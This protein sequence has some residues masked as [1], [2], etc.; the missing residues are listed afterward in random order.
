MSRI[1]MTW[2]QAEW[3]VLSPAHRRS[4]QPVRLLRDR[5]PTANRTSLA[6]G[7]TP[8]HNPHAI[9]TFRGPAL[10]IWIVRLPFGPVVGQS[11]SRAFLLSPLGLRQTFGQAR[12]GANRNGRRQIALHSPLPLR[13]EHLGYIQNTT[14]LVTTLP[15]RVL[16]YQQLRCSQRRHVVPT[17]G[18]IHQPTIGI[19][20]GNL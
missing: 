12:R 5:C 2:P 17:R 9:R 4:A 6:P 20:A 7:R 8:L 18:P 15:T 1:A 14:W 3:S 19:L 13:R 10:L 16:S 11:A